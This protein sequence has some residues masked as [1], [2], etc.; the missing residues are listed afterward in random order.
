M[1]AGALS[2]LPVYGA[3]SGSPADDI[4]RA[5]PEVQHV[6]TSTDEVADA[7]QAMDAGLGTL[8]AVGHQ[9]QPYRDYTVFLSDLWG[10]LFNESFTLTSSAMVFDSWIPDGQGAVPGETTGGTALT[11]SIILTIETPLTEDL[12][13]SA[14]EITD[15]GLLDT[16]FGIAWAEVSTGL[17]TARLFGWWLE[18]T[19]TEETSAVFVPVSVVSETDCN[20]L[21]FSAPYIVENIDTIW[22]EGDGINEPQP[23]AGA[24]SNF[25][26][27]LRSAARVAAVAVGVG[28]VAAVVVAAAPF[29][30]AAALGTTVTAAAAAT[31]AA[32]A[33]TSV[34][35]G[36]AVAAVIFDDKVGTAIDELRDQLQDDLPPPLDISGLTDEQVVD[37][38]EQFYR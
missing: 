28:V 14:Q 31:V 25:R 35:A 1:L 20:S 9:P 15:L 11:A 8:E 22:S 6:P 2:C 4:S 3:V 38:A 12:G 36:A 32:G 29:V 24:W 13:I 17:S 33:A 37:L 10:L 16:T 23:R 19:C 26:S 34:V 5:Y 21:V 27:K 18:M 7:V 30:V